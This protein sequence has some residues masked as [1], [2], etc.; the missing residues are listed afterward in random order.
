[1]VTNIDDGK[2]RVRL[3]L[4]W[5]SPDYETDW[6]PVIQFGAGKR[7]GAMFLPE[8]GDEVL[9][10][11]EFGDPRRPYVIGG[12]VNNASSYT[13]GGPAVEKTGQIAAVARRG[14]VSAAGNSLVF[15]DKIPPGDAG[16][17]PE[18]S[19]ITLGTGDGNLSL[20]IDQVAGTVTLSCS[21]AAPG[22][23]TEKGTL[24]IQC[25]TAGTINV[26]AGQGG[27]VNIDGGA[28]L[29]L[30]AEGSISIQSQGSVSIQGSGQVSIKGAQIALN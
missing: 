30:K 29:N 2:G 10:G 1:V 3:V 6:A 22:S 8:V 17:P 28:N 27:T 19:A 5:L 23:K 9:V 15:A 21:P 20:S 4:P 13:L 24:N 26:T 14:F 11:F 7:S 25:G 12:I 18:V 16:G